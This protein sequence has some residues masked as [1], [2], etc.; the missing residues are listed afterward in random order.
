MC[1]L[2]LATENG[3][4]LDVLRC[5]W[6]DVIHE[7][8]LPSFGSGWTNRKVCHELCIGKHFHTHIILL[9][10]RGND[11]N[12]H[13]RN[14][15]QSDCSARQCAHITFVTVVVPC[16]SVLSHRSRQPSLLVCSQV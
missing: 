16:L 1:R 8:P 9:P 15:S 11:L 2:E 7:L 6:L 3:H 5:G 10:S 4:L 14:H 13:N 12:H